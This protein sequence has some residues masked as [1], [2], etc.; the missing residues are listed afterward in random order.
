MENISV[1]KRNK[2]QATQATNNAL[3]YIIQ[4]H[5]ETT[6]LF[7]SP[8]TTV[9]ILVV[10]EKMVCNFILFFYYTPMQ[11]YLIPLRKN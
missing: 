4:Q 8:F 5:S 9:I 10:T 7:S 2:A 6:G 1:S 3:E 11:L